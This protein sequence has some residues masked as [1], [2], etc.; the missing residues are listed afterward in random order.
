MP[1]AA[2]QLPTPRRRGSGI[3][4]RRGRTEPRHHRHCRSG[5]LVVTVITV[6]SLGDEKNVLFLP[7]FQVPEVANPAQQVE[8][9]LTA[10]WTARLDPQQRVG[11][12]DHITVRIDLDTAY[13]FDAATGL[14][15]RTTLQEQ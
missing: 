6:E 3:P 10:M 5:R 15:I 2:G 11:P 12:G 13:Y 1:A 14:A 4:A 9:E 8:T 7:P